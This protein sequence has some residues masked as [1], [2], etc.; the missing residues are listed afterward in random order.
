MPAM[1]QATIE[2]Q[3]KRL[4]NLRAFCEK[5]GLPYRTLHRI[6]SGGCTANT[7]TLAAIDAA[8]KKHKPPMR[9]EAP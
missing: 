7:V 9:P 2:A 8:L 5:A 4:E 1:H 3:L 6:K